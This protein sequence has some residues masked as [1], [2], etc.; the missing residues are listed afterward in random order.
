MIVHLSSSLP[1]NFHPVLRSVFGS[2]LKMAGSGDMRHFTM[3]VDA[4][5]TA[6]CSLLV[7]AGYDKAHASI[8]LAYL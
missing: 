1:M 3:T 5:G 8:G 4:T 7:F 2:A 6:N